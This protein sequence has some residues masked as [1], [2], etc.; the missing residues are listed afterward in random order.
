MGELHT[1]QKNNGQGKGIVKK[2]KKL[3][4]GFIFSPGCEIPP[5]SNPENVMAMT[6]AV[7][8]FGWY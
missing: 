8:D 3:S 5:K 6:K 7:N 2:G 4:T 1:E